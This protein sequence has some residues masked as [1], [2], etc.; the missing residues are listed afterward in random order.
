MAIDRKAIHRK[1]VLED[2]WIGDAVLALYARVKILR[3]D[4]AL[5]QEK[6]IRMT[7]NRFLAVLGEPSEMEADIGRIYERDGLEAAF[8]FIEATLMPVFERQ[9]ENR[10]KRGY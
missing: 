5:D 6:F 4:G 9:E 10:R 8:Q 1:K 2:A 3:G 7:S